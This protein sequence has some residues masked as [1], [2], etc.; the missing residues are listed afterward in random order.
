[1]LKTKRI[2]Q[3]S[4]GKCFALC[5]GISAAALLVLSLIGALIAAMLDDPTGHLGVISL[6]VMLLS[7]MVGGVISSRIRGEG[8]VGFAT[9]TALAIVLIMLIINI[10]TCAGK[11]S[12]GAFMNYACYL[13]AASLFSYLGRKK[14]GHIRHKK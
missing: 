2:S 14:S 12:P 3:L 13:G 5:I 6:V 9:L 4:T 1:M 11:V 8:G 7:A 10:I